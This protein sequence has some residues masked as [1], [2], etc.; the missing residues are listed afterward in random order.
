MA[1]LGNERYRLKLADGSQWFIA[2]G[3]G[4]AARIVSYFGEAMHLSPVEYPDEWKTE[5]PLPVQFPEEPL[6][7]RL[8]VFLDGGHPPSFLPRVYPLKTFEDPGLTV[9]SLPSWDS[10]SERYFHLMELSL[11][12]AHQ[13]QSRG[14]VLLHGA[15]A[16]WKGLGIILAGAGG[17]AKTTASTR[18]PAPWK[19]LSDDLTLV[20]RDSYQNYWAHPWPTWSRFLT[21]G[22]GGNWQVQNAIPLGAIFFLNQASEDR[23]VPLGKGEAV[24]PLLS[25]T[26]QASNLMVKGLLPEETRAL[27]LEWLKNLCDLSQAVTADL[28]NISL[29]GPFWQEIEKVIKKKL[30]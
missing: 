13:V 26:R 23:V 5:N 8:L 11:I 21:E 28:L 3:N 22:P 6:V 24:G 10:E 27:H 20:V 17:T 9:C 15:L 4:P 30:S 29:T 2:A 12:L 16:E 19:S 18:L 7:H 14:G 25:S 1:T